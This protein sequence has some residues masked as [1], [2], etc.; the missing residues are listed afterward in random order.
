MKKTDFISKI[1]EQKKLRIQEQKSLVSEEQLKEKINT[2]SPCRPFKE[3][4]S[5]SNKINLIAEVKKASPSAGVIR[6]NFN[7]VEI[8]K[9][10][11]RCGAQ[12]ISVLTEVDSFQGD[13]QYLQDIKQQTSLPILRKDFILEPYQVYESRANGADAI[14]L[15]ISILNKD[16]LV[17]LLDLATQLDLDC[18]VEIHDD[19]ELKRILTLKKEFIIGVNNRN[20]SDFKVELETSQKILPFIPKGNIIVAESG[21]KSYQDVLFLKLLRVNAVLVGE[22][23]MRAPDIEMQVK[24]VMGW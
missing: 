8:A 22:T 4:I 9:I 17:G 18:I 1:I 2:L 15:I 24:E 19:K 10:Y 21:I 5:K 13:L 23:F 12:A 14:L 6:E 3:T 7:P 20:L 16:E 11:E